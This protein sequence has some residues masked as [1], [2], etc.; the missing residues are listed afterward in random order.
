MDGISL[1][2]GS[3]RQHI[4]SFAAE[5]RISGSSSCPC[6]GGNSPPAFVGKDYF[7][8]SGSN[9]TSVNKI[10]YTSDPLW[11]GQGC[12]GGE[13]PCCQA[14]GIPWFHKVLNTSTTD[15]I[16]LRMNGASDED[17]PLSLYEIY[18]K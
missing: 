18:V 16:E 3:P 9:G 7:C 17:S 4:W 13:A 12:V 8:E 5:R 1:T 14:T 11:D 6:A 15:F 2:H 10:M